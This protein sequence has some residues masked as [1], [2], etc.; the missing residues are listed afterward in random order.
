MTKSKCVIKKCSNNTLTT[1][2][3]ILLYHPV[4]MAAG[5]SSSEKP[6]YKIEDAPQL[7]KK[8]IKDYDRK[9]A[10][11]EDRKIH[12]D[13]FVRNLAKINKAN[14]TIP[15]ATFDINKY[16]DFTREESRHL[17]GLSKRK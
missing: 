10:N 8:F 7:F 16:S 17:L 2:T 14:A 6:Y 9:Y 4:K 3:E 15:E 11:D 5:K 12:Y 1:Q 13:A